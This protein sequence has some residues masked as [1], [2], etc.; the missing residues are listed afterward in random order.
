[1]KKSLK[2]SKFH[3]HLNQILKLKFQNDSASYENILARY[4]NFWTSIVIV[5]TVDLAEEYGSHL[6]SILLKI[7]AW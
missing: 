3:K 4:S 7:R 1:M 2:Q 5:L 6:P